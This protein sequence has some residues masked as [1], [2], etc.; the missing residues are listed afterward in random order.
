MYKN[1]WLLSGGV[2]TLVFLLLFTLE[3]SHAAEWSLLNNVSIGGIYTDNVNLVE[4]DSELK[5]S[6]LIGVVAPGILLRGE[7]RRAIVD[8]AV[9][10]IF[11]TSDDNPI[12]PRYRA[13][14]GTELV[15]K[16]LSRKLSGELRYGLGK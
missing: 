3:V 9:S 11:N 1:K 12:L 7:G 16:N 4:D 14:V 10:L 6:E 13:F 5:E 2:Q 15:K 8:L